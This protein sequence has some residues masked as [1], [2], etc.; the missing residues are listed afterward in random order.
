MT[1]EAEGIE[2]ISGPVV[3]RSEIDRRI[4]RLRAS[5]GARPLQAVLAL[6]RVEVLYFAGTP[7]DGILWIPREGEPAFLVRRDL[8]RARRE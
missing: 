3:P 5:L 6:Q 1:S 8:E 2:G 7:Q 4:G